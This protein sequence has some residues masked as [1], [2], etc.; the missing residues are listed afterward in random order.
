M[1]PKKIVLVTL[2][3]PPETGGVARYLSD[4]VEA[5]AGEMR[6]IVPETHA[7]EEKDV[8][9]AKPMFWSAKPRWWP[10][11][12]LFRSLS[13]EK[14][15][16][17]VSHVFPVGTAALIGRLL[18]GPE[19]IVLFHGLDLKLVNSWRKKFLLSLIVRFAKGIA[20]NS[21][22]TAQLLEEKLGKK[23][24]EVILLTPGIKPRELLSKKDAREQLG[25]PAGKFVV[26]TVARFVPRKG[27]D[28]TIQAIAELQK[29][30]NV[31][32][33]VIG[34]GT[35]RGRLMDMAKQARVDVTWASTDEQEKWVWYAACDAFCMPAREQADDIE[36]FGIVYLEAALAEKPSIA[37]NT[38]GAREAV[39][40][41]E[42][43]I[44]VDANNL[45]EIAKALQS[46][47]DQPE[48]AQTL[49][50]QA[51]ERVLRDF[52]WKQRWEKLETLRR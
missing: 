23:P 7:I 18:G 36:G 39:I 16:A 43:G 33:V 47:L 14:E 31:Q 45:T 26:L 46:L 42:T 2:D 27:I 48:L 52:A 28:A 49:G 13:R 9:V 3:Y 10:M 34:S 4:L 32:Y 51:K 29:T 20:T 1:L 44:I 40:H 15:I 22:A 11:V 19:Y 37:G 38:G 50:K 30:R 25:I 24:K 35:D 6:V 17:F 41:Q 5:A 8:V 21:Q 12:G